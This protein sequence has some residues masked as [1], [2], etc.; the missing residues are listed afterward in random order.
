MVGVEETKSPS[1]ALAGVA[2]CVG[3]TSAGETVI[4]AQLDF[5]VRGAPGLVGASEEVLR[6]PGLVLGLRRAAANG[7]N[8]ELA[9]LAL[10]AAGPG[11]SALRVAGGEFGAPGHTGLEWWMLPDRPTENP[12]A[13]RLPSGVVVALKHSRNPSTEDIRAFGQ[14]PVAGAVGMPGFRRHYGGDCGGSDHDGYYWYESTG[15][16][17]GEWSEVSRLPGGTVIGLKHSLH[18]PTK[19]FTWAGLLYDPADP[20]LEPPAGFRRVA[21]HDLA[22]GGDDGFFWYEKVDGPWTAT[23]IETTHDMEE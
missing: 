9:M 11:G 18:Q 5:D 6:V 15:A 7:R 13:W 17:F 2:F 14:D 10:G 3:L 1:V 22:N 23:P 21:A 8:G 12:A 19:T 16:G 20:R 4:T